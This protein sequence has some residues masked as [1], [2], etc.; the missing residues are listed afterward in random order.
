MDAV[1]T[2]PDA[3]WMIEAVVGRADRRRVIAL[4]W[5]QIDADLYWDAMVTAGR[6][7]RA[8]KVC[9]QTSGLRTVLD[10]FDRVEEFLAEVV[11]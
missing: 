11:A 6:F 9:A 10:E 2:K 8:W 3:Y 4:F 5:S 7:R 1:A